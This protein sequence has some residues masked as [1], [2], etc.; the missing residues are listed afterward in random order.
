M[1]P[2]WTFTVAP[3]GDTLTVL[4]ETPLTGSIT[5]SPRPSAESAYEN[6]HG[7]VSIRYDWLMTPRSGATRTPTPF[8]SGSVGA[9]V[10]KIENDCLY[11]R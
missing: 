7:V 4:I 11:S 2:N 1:P 3:V 8:T 6:V 10:S 9:N 5:V